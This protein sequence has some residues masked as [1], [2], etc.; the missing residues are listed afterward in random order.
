[1]KQGL[2]VVNG[3]DGSVTVFGRSGLEM[4]ML[5]NGGIIA[6]IAS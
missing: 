4:V 3:I 1:M 5:P 2:A 6:A